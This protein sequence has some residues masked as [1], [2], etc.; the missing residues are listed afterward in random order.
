MAQSSEAER[1]IGQPNTPYYPAIHCYSKS[2]F[3]HEWNWR[4]FREPTG[5]TLEPTRF[6]HYGMQRLKPSKHSC[7]NLPPLRISTFPASKLL[8]DV[9]NR[10]NKRWGLKCEVAVW[11]RCRCDQTRRRLIR[12]WTWSFPAFDFFS[13]SLL[14]YVIYIYIIYTYIYICPFF[15]GAY[16]MM[17]THLFFRCIF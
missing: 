11:C 16:E 2:F 15:L 9:R 8:H 13:T 7:S 3:F 4:D 10:N 14:W 12:F 1:D 17:V 5:T 6:T